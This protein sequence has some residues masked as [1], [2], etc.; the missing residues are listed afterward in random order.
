MHFSLLLRFF[1]VKGNLA[2]LGKSFGKAGSGANSVTYDGKLCTLIDMIYP[3][4]YA[5]Y[6]IPCPS[7]GPLFNLHLPPCTDRQNFNRFANNV[8][9]L[10]VVSHREY[11]YGNAFDINCTSSEE[12]WGN[13][14][15]GEKL[16]IEMAKMYYFRMIFMKSFQVIVVYMESA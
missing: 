9:M 5:I 12:E 10:P 2:K 13:A 11:F 16:F 15:V 14:T 3:S 7:Q 4:S 8:D 1:A 6:D